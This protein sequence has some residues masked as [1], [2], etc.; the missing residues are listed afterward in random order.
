MSFV[1]YNVYDGSILS[2]MSLNPMTGD[3]SGNPVFEYEKSWG[4]IEVEYSQVEKLL[5]GTEHSVEYVVAYSQVNNEYELVRR[6]EFTSESLGISDLIFQVPILQHEDFVKYKKLGY[7]PDIHII[8]DIPNTC[9]NIKF[10]DRADSHAHGQFLDLQKHLVFSITQYNNP[11]ILYRILPIKLENL[12]YERYQVI[13]FMYDWEKS[14]EPVSIFTIKRFDT[15]A[16]QRIDNE[17]I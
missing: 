6:Q 2:I 5:D 4:Y 7:Q 9:W 10:G 15:Y 12:V 3:L 14:D 16:Y 13:P 11:N 17:K 1:C 8:H